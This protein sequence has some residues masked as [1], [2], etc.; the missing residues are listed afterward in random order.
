MTETAPTL[1]DVL[2]GDAEAGPKQ[3]LP[4]VWEAYRSERAAGVS[5]FTAAVIVASQVDRLGFAFAVGYPAALEHMIEGV[6]LPCALCVTEANGNSPRAIESTLAPKGN[7]YQLD[8]AKTFVTFGN[9]AETLIIVAKAGEKSDGRPDLAVVQIPANRKGVV[10]QELPET[11][12]VPEVP[13]TSVR[14]DGVEV[15]QNERLPGD[16]YLNY[17]K[18][19]RTIE[20][21]HV[22]GTTLGYL[23]GLARRTRASATLIAELSADLVALDRL[24]DE[25]PLDPRVHIALHGV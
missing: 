13:H 24:R 12:F 15:L 1:L 14:L 7:R 4:E 21:I 6:R 19:F 2:S 11:P 5:P 25:A 3:S 9:H 8:G 16:G 18:P 17:V 20:D 23:V 22:V 10:L